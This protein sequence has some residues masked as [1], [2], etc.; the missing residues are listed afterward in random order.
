[1]RTLAAFDF[2]GTL[3]YRDT[4]IPFLSKV[5][6]P[7]K[8]SSDLLMTLP[9]FLQFFTGQKSR[10]EVKE[11]LLSRS[12]GGLDFA[13]CQKIGAGFAAAELEGHLRERALQK[14]LWHQR[15]GHEV[16]VISANLN[17][18][19]DPWCEKWNLQ[20]MICS[21]LEEDQGKV[22][23]KL[24]GLNCWGPEKVRRLLEW[25]GPKKGFTLFAYGDSRGDREL[26]NLA[27]YPHFKT[28]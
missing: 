7:V 12:I 20:Q 18:F 9:A 19:L 26:L 21:R 10:Q 13:E 23:G 17:L 3:T 28:F 25:A 24:L 15:E 22:S 8:L 11:T 6:G 4:L 27:D 1:M 14:L 5:K 2:D 16:I